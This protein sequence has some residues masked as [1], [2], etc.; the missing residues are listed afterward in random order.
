MLLIG[1]SSSWIASGGRRGRYS[2]RRLKIE[3]V[4]SVK[5]IAVDRFGYLRSF[6]DSFDLEREKTVA[7]LARGQKGV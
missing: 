2:F 1:K 5:T 6:R 4:S 7:A 3:E